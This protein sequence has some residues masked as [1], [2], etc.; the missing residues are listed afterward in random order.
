MFSKVELPVSENNDGD[1]R[2]YF[3]DKLCLRASARTV[4]PLED[5]IDILVVMAAGL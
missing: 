4:W 2:C 3:R 1:I 5:T